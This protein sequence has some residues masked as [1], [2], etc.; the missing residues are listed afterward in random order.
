MD[1]IV[2]Y[3]KRFKNSPKKIII[4][5]VQF[6][7]ILS[8]LFVSCN[9]TG[10][11][12]IPVDSAIAGEKKFQVEEV[13]QTSSYTYFKA[14]E[15]SRERW[16]AVSK[17]D[18]GAGE[19]FYYDKALEMNDF[20]SKELDRTFERIYFINQ[21]SKTPLS[22]IEAKGMPAH[23]DKAQIPLRDEVS[24]DKTKDELTLAGLFA[25]SSDYAQK[26]VEIRGIVVKVNKD[27]MGKNWIHI[28][29]GTKHG[30]KYD[31]TVTSQDLPSVNDEVVFKGTLS[32]NRDFGAGYYYDVIL[33]DADWINKKQGSAL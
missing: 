9:H 21:I 27:I 31:L 30:D 25:N 3:D 14:S 5:K 23:A 20:Y 15:N 11:K 24:I 17:I 28:Q 10:N 4:M 22:D 1:F 32:V 13:I 18:A 19:V 7:L 2:T 12:P 16:V 29:D 33:E 8:V 6:F 26:Q